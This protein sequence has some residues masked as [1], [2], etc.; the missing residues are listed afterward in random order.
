[1]GCERY[2]TR[3][4]FLYPLFS[5]ATRRL[6]MIR[7]LCPVKPWWHATIPQ[8]HRYA[9]NPVRVARHDDPPL[10]ALMLSSRA[11]LRRVLHPLTGNPATASELVSVE[12]T[13]SPDARQHDRLVTIFSIEGLYSCLLRALAP[14]LAHKRCT[15]HVGTIGAI[16]CSWL[17]TFFPA[18]TES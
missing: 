13:A 12:A 3:E 11:L 16:L 10:L 15:N 9:L 7:C 2:H 8:Y 5:E 1:M 4:R 14:L 18:V 6:I 17:N